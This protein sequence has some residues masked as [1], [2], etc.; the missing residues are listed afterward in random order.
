MKH[1][2]VFFDVDGTITNYKDGTIA[3]ST[4]A[5]IRKLLDMGIQVVAATGRPL[6]MCDEIAKLGINTFI[7]ANGAYVKHNDIVIHKIVL[8]QEIVKEVMKYASTEKNAL[9]FY[10]EK[11]Q[12]NNIKH[13]MILKALNETLLLEEYPSENLAA[14]EEETYLMCLFANEDMIQKYKVRFPQLTFK[15][16]HPFILNVL[17]EDV[18]KSKAII[19]VLEY[20]GLDKSEAVAFG[21][22]ENDM[23]M[24]EMV[25]VGIA[26]G[27]AGEKLKSIANFVTSE[28]SEDGIAI[29]L[30]K[31]SLI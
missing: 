4:K 31:Y 29:A 22:G 25:D 28:S 21:D 30:K 12:M 13:P 23:D 2:I 14:Y 3:K 26:M 19:K 8:N 7:T 9:T 24:L 6:S 27:N 5:A 10:S 1:K 16:W 17:E 18:S 11:L 15:R 20:F